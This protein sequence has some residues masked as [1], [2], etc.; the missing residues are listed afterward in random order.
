[1][2]D[3]ALRSPP[4]GLGRRFGVAD[5]AIGA[6]LLAVAYLTLYPFLMIAFSSMSDPQEILRNPIFL[7]PRSFT[8]ATYKAVIEYDEVV[9]GFRNSILYTAVYTALLLAVTAAAAYA[10]SRRRFRARRALLILFLIPWFFSGGIIPTYVVVQRMGLLDTM[11][12]F[13]FTIPGLVNFFYLIMLR[14]AMEQIGEEL[15]ESAVIDG[16][17]D[18]QIFAGVVA[19]LS[20]AIIATIALWA[21]IGQ[22]NNYFGPV[23][24]LSDV[25][26]YPLQV[27]LR[28]LVATTQLQEMAETQAAMME[29]AEDLRRLRERLKTESLKAAVIVISTAPILIVYPFIQRYFVKGAMVGAIKG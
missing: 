22:W 9:R 28:N 25:K 24:Y 7:Y 6:A 26:K 12:A 10:L 21:A 1:M 20:K 17:N 29:T 27:V 18:L 19:P 5:A 13:T 3:A 8:L 11:W 23:L 14:T 2:G 15:I 4:A 16:A